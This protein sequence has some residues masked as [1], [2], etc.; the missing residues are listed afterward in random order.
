[1]PQGD[2]SYEPHKNFA[3][4]TATMSDVDDMTR[5]HRD[6]FTEEPQVHYCYPW[7]DQYPE[8]YWHWTRKEYTS[9]PEQPQKYV[10]QVIEAL[11]T[12]DGRTIKETVGLAIWN[13][14]VL[15]KADGPGKSRVS[16]MHLPK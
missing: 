15:T 14:A 12:C 11:C 2:G 3:V 10:V 8:D 4:R 5:I 6:G 7:R 16:R 13:V 1:M 9:Y